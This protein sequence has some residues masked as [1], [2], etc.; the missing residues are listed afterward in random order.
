M[1]VD[2]TTPKSF[3]ALSSG[4]YTKPNISQVTTRFIDHEN[5]HLFIIHQQEVAPR[6]SA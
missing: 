4:V 2:L 6:H 1:D 3:V 5:Q